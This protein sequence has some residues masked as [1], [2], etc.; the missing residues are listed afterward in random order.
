MNGLRKNGTSLE[1]ASGLMVS[2]TLEIVRIN[3][4]YIAAASRFGGKC[5]EIGIRLHHP[6]ALRVR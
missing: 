3:A 6:S 4:R 2:G 1:M 5:A